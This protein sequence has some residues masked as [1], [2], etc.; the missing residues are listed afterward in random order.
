MS[1]GNELV[2]D[3]RGCTRSQFEWVHLTQFMEGLCTL[4]RMERGPLHFW[5]YEPDHEARRRAPENLA[6]VSVVQF[7]STS[8]ITVHTLDHLGRVYLNIFSCREFSAEDATD[9]CLGFFQGYIVSST[10]LVRR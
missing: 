9:F 2:L 10:L 1:F 8:N 4:L 7:I 5:D 3:L 6:G